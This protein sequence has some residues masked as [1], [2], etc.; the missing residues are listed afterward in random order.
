[1][2]KFIALPRGLSTKAANQT[3]TGQLCRR[4]AQQRV[5]KCTGW[6]RYFHYVLV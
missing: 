6:N 5:A 4:P 2:G 1:V 3:T